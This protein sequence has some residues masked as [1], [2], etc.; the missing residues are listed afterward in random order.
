MKHMDRAKLSKEL[1]KLQSL[2]NHG[3]ELKVVWT[4]KKDFNLDGEIKGHVIYVYSPSFEVAMKTLHHEF[5]DYAVSQCVD[6]YKQVANQLI[7]LLNKQAYDRKEKLVD[8][9]ADL[10]P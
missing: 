4:P 3:H 2:L 10:L 1:K 5:L 7:I 9:L 8:K 6:P